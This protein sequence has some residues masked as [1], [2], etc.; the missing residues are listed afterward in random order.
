MDRLGNGERYLESEVHT[1]TNH[2]APTVPQIEKVLESFSEHNALSIEF[3][4]LSSYLWKPRHHD[5]TIL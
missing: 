5:N 2:H 3:V 1:G 4:G